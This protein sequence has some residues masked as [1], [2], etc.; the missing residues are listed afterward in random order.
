MTK[1]YGALVVGEENAALAAAQQKTAERYGPNVLGPS[2]DPSEKG[3]Q[4]REASGKPAGGAAD[5]AVNE[6]VAKYASDD[7]YLSIANVKDVLAEMP[8]AFDRMLGWEM[9]REDGPR[10]G[11][12]THF[13]EVESQRKG[14]PRANILKTLETTLIRVR[15]KGS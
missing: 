11:A 15:T 6:I 10:I 8:G 3:E 4:K 14:G 13:I 9:G 2:V 7:G 5:D 1:P 12:L